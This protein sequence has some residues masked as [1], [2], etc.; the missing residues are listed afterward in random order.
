MRHHVGCVHKTPQPRDRGKTNKGPRMQAEIK[1]LKEC[2][3]TWLH[4]SICATM[5]LAG[6]GPNNVSRRDGEP[7]PRRGGTQNTASQRRTTKQHGK[8]KDGS[9]LRETLIPKITRPIKRFHGFAS[10]WSLLNQ[11]KKRCCVSRDFTAA[12]SAH[13]TLKIKKHEIP[14]K[15]SRTRAETNRERWHITIDAPNAVLRIPENMIPNSDWSGPMTRIQN[16]QKGRVAKNYTLHHKSGP[17]VPLIEGEDLRSWQWQWQWHI[18]MRF[19]QMS[20]LPYGLEWGGR[21]LGKKESVELIRAC[22]RAGCAIQY[23]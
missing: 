7:R 16:C 6:S 13:V 4:F 19:L 18:R 15:S 5:F 3:K 17:G 22:S 8:G 2:H 14:R 12:R 23:L 9:K 21:N 20:T 1:E 11:R 10:S